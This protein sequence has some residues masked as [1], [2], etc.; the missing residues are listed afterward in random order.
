MVINAGRYSTKHCN[1]HYDF[2]LKLN[3]TAHL[4]AVR[5]ALLVTSNWC[6]LVANRS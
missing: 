3:I 1:N 5:S 4:R 6:C 2:R